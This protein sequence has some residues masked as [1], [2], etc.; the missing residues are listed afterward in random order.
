MGGCLMTQFVG[1]DVPQKLTAICVVGDTGQRLCRG[2]RNSDPEQIERAVRRHAGDGAGIGLVT[3]SPPAAR[4]VAYLLRDLETYVSGQSEPFI[5]YA[6]E[7]WTIFG[8]R[9]TFPTTLTLGL[10]GANDPPCEN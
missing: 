2:Q 3:A 6:T 9:R 7:N 8:N 1:L 10:G 4:R 5:D